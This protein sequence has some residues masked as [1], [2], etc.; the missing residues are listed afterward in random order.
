DA[1]N[2]IVLCVEQHTLALVVQQVDGIE[3]YASQA[4]QNSQGLF[5]AHLA[6]FVEGYL[7]E[8]GSIALDARAIARAP[9][10]QTVLTG[11]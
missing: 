4:I 11:H 1:L 6:P 10:L 5:P 2:A 7:R 9:R 8:A 3:A